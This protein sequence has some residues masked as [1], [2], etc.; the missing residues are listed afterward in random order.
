LTPLT[1]VRSPHHQDTGFDQAR[2]TDR[3]GCHSKLIRRSAVIELTFK[4][5]N[6]VMCQDESRHDYV[7]RG[8]TGMAGYRRTGFR[9]LIQSEPSGP[10]HLRVPTS[11]SSQPRKALL[12]H[13]SRR[14]KALSASSRW[15]PG[16]PRPCAKKAGEGRGMARTSPG[17]DNLVSSCGLKRLTVLVA[18]SGQ[19]LRP[20]ISRRRSCPGAKPLRT[21]GASH[22][23]APAPIQSC[24]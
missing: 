13:L 5:N 7:L 18:F 8:R 9:A 19:A 3:A 23:R 4:R 21:I 17:H 24:L 2:E 16:H 10:A 20:G 14:A 12:W 15:M 6:A 11:K 1:S 22:V